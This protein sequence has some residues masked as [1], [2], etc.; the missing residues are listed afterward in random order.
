M[1]IL[2]TYDSNA[3]LE[4]G[5]KSRTGTELTETYDILYK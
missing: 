4:E 2:Y 3:I 5:C 1:M